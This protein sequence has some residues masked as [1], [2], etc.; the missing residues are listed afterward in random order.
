MG[1]RRK[2]S[3]GLG[4]EAVSVSFGLCFC[5]VGR[6][7]TGRGEPS[8]AQ[9]KKGTTTDDLRQSLDGYFRVVCLLFFY[10]NGSREETT[11][12]DN[13]CRA[14]CRWNKQ[15]VC[16]ERPVDS[17]YGGEGKNVSLGAAAGVTCYTAMPL[18]LHKCNYVLV[19]PPPVPETCRVLPYPE[20]GGVSLYIS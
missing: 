20:C 13:N 10:R 2:Q 15:L 8:E 1:G 5:K 11:S 12:T 4:S 16:C 7:S 3:V 6:T 18:S 17:Q 19:C 9:Y 14:S